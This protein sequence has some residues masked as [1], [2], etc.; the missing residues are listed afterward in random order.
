MQI[1]NRSM[2]HTRWIKTYRVPAGTVTMPSSLV[3]LSSMPFL[4]IPMIPCSTW[5][6]SVCFQ[7]ICLYQGYEFQRDLYRSISTHTQEWVKGQQVRRNV[8][9]WAGKSV[10]H[11]WIINVVCFPHGPSAILV[12][13]EV[14]MSPV[15]WRHDIRIRGDHRTKGTRREPQLP[16]PRHVYSSIDL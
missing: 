5:K 14:E 2:V 16:Y 9:G 13:E 10:F 12:F 3:I 8:Q 7:W 4:C 1:A 6:Y 11:P 15:I